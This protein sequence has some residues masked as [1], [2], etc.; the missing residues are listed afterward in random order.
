M[1]NDP[2]IQNELSPPPG[3]KGRVEGL[4]ENWAL[5]RIY[6]FA[7]FDPTPEYTWLEADQ[8]QN[9]HLLRPYP[10]LQSF[11]WSLLLEVFPSLLFPR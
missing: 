9:G 5:R 6:V 1:S 11:L 3:D 7:E 2:P 10:N 4:P 8:I